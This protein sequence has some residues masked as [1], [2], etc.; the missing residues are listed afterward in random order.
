MRS[1]VDG[2]ADEGARVVV[3]GSA[4]AAG[5]RDGFFVG[6]SLLDRVEPGMRVYDDEIFGP[7][8]SVVRVGT[9]DEASR[10]STRNPYGNGVALFT[11]DGGAARRFER[12]VKVGMVGI[13]V[14]I[15]VPVAWHS[16]GGWKASLFGDAP[17]Y[18]PEGIRFYTRPKV[19]TSRWPDPATERDRPRLPH[20]PLNR[21]QAWSSTDVR[22]SSPEA[23]AASA[24]PPRVT[25]WRSGWAWRSSTA[26]PTARPSSPRSWATPRSRPTATSTT[27]T[28]SAPRSRRRARSARSR[29]WST[30]PAAA[31]GGG[32]TVGRG[33]TPHDKDA[34]VA[35]MEM[36]AF[37][38]FNVS[39]LAAAAMADNEPDDDGQRGVIVNTGSIAGSKA[40]PARSRTRRRRPRSSA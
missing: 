15:P 37:G 4:A 6:C 39:R 25:S 32:R 9:F 29:S 18:G 5:L 36:N 16:F 14:P 35:T 1:Y 27:T 2:A 38:T 24:P 7:V 19:V 26:T 12:E 22:R 8:L 23:R 20:Q 21:E 13:N 17:I 10:S 3:D 40:R 34:F 30:S 33:G 11:R 31:L 28:T